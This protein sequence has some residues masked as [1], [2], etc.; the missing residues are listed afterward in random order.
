MN[1]LIQF[2][3]PTRKGQIIKVIG[4]GGGGGNAVN[5][6]YKQ[7][8]E[9]VDFVLCNT[10]E[11]ALQGSDIPTKIQ[12]GPTLTQGLGA[13]ADPSVGESACIE[14]VDELE[15]ILKDN[16]KMVFVTAG[17]GGGTGTGAAPVISEIAKG[18]G[19]L[20]VGIVTTP[21]HHEGPRRRQQAEEGIAK[22]RQYVDTILVVS[23]DKVRQQYGNVGFRNAFSR[24]DDILATA[25][26]CITDIIN[27]RG[28]VIV[29]F[30]DVC[31]VMRNGGVAILGNA[32]A[33]GENRA[34][35][36]IDKALNSPL[37]N[38]NNIEG[39]R[40]VLI[41]VNSPEGEFEFTLDENEIIQ[42][43]VRKAAGKQCDVILGLGTDDTLGEGISVTV[44]ATGFHGQDLDEAFAV[45]EE[46]P[47]EGKTILALEPTV[48]VAKVAD[49]APIV[50]STAPQAAIENTMAAPAEEDALMPKL[51][52]AQAETT[53]PKVVS[54]GLRSSVSPLQKAI[55][56]LP[57][58]P[59]VTEPITFE[60]TAP[61]VEDS[62]PTYTTS[63]E[64]E[65]TP[66]V[67][68]EPTPSIPVEATPRVEPIVSTPQFEMPQL[69]VSTNGNSYAPQNITTPSGIARTVYPDAPAISALQ[70]PV[71]T[72]QLKDDWVTIEGITFNRKRGNSY[73]DEAEMR[74]HVA[75]E[76][77]KRRLED[78]ASQLRAV[79]HVVSTP[80]LHSQLEHVPSYM[81]QGTELDAMHSSANAPTSN[82]SN[83]GVDANGN[84]ESKNDFL[85]GEVKC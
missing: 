65:P 76:Q 44:I 79:S 29:D 15:S 1:N 20:T 80:Q 21:F 30:A 42:E 75:L 39:A 3:M 60:L 67:P 23:N 5:Y 24:A 53:A 64:V 55:Q 70:S 51:I 66:S 7:G 73:M 2:E 46:N 25:T 84:L 69:N 40:W 19:I 31:T 4:V 8:I 47:N 71:V 48:E 45:K 59:S 36:A 77:S 37:L 78:R 38:D 43:Y 27:S 17:M 83:L 13:G 32:V 52:V 10:D 81:R 9:G 12:L 33:T 62:A 57:Q 72:E 54:I 63:A 41:N 74:E 85:D 16:T 82:I 68:V 49:E 28:H 58:T 34:Q 14:S 6:M 18:L 61:V 50:E 35:E 11:K 22:M 26:K 56:Q